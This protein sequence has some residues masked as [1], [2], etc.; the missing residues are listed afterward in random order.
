MF[1]EVQQLSMGYIVYME[2][3]IKLKLLEADELKKF[4]GGLFCGMAI[5]VLTAAA[6]SE[7]VR[8]RLTPV[9]VNFHLGGESHA[10]SSDET[11]ILN[12]NGSLYVPLRSFA[13]EMGGSVYYTPPTSGDRAKVDIYYEDD[14]DLTLQDEDGYV[15]LGNLDVQFALDDD[16][17][18]ISGTIKVEKIIP[19]NKDVVIA[20]LDDSGETLGVSSALKPNKPLHVPLSQL[21]PGEMIQFRNYF[22][23]MATPE[24]YKL[25]VKLV[26]KED[27]YYDQGYVG[28]VTGA[29]GFNGFPLN[30]ALGFSPFKPGES[31]PFIVTLLNRSEEDTVVTTKPL[32]L[33]V[34][35]TDSEGKVIRTLATK[36]FKGEVQWR[37]GMMQTELIWDLKDELGNKVPKGDYFF[38][39]LENETEGYMK[40]NPDK[41]MTFELEWSMQGTG[42]F[43]V[44]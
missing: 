32:Q 19:K 20:I 5:M 29:G 34:E 1:S 4:I 30:A 22:P 38:S 39:I 40:G 13:N 10:I 2:D 25:Q 15:K 12:H 44:E 36:P 16:M 41:S 17:P 14:R 24:D 42:M 6:V 33:V 23:Y 31:I 26:D 18:V 28:S 11:K 27:W 9:Y 8:A 21:Q 35:I 37:H 7:E 43:T 3:G